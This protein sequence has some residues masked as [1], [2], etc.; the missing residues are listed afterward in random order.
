MKQIAQFSPVEFVS[1]L[2]DLHVPDYTGFKEGQVSMSK[3][4]SANSSFGGNSKASTLSL[5]MQNVLKGKPEA[6][7][8]QRDGFSRV[9]TGQG[10]RDNFIA[11][12]SVINKYQ[13]EFKSV[14]ELAK[15]FT[16]VDFLQEMVNDGCF[17]LDCI[18]F[19]GT[20]L[21][22]AG[23]VDS[24]EPRRP[25]DYTALFKP[26]KSL[27]EIGDFGVVMLTN[28]MHIQI[29]NTVKERGNG[30][31]KV[32]LCQSSSGDADG[33]QYNSMVTI[34]S[35]GGS[36]LPIE[37]FRRAL[38]SNQYAAEHATDNANRKQSGQKELDY[39]SFLRAKLTQQNVQ[40]GYCNGA[41]FQLLSDGYPNRN[42]VGGSVYV[43]MATNGLA[44]R[45]FTSFTRD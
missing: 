5:A 26:V 7:V 21:A 8:L 1:K 38:S 36:Y 4:L 33:P 34:K 13:N 28:G 35:G 25:L 11:A 42:P 37:E 14:Q 20:Y 39:E 17:G 44:V 2:M 43:G 6:N 31:I 10:S 32:G 16:K 18:G 30:F 3:Y 29:I 27:D 45:T 22:D 24:Y 41:I 40:T 9:F 15:Y 19:V 12:L 23:L